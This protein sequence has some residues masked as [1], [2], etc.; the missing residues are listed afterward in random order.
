MNE[1]KRIKPRISDKPYPLAIEMRPLWRICLIVISVIIVSG[2]KKYL[3][4]KKVNILVWMLIRRN[5]WD[6]YGEYLQGRNS[7]IPFVSVDTSTYKAVEFSIAKGFVSL[8]DGRLYVS[9]IAEN[10]YS[11]L[12]NSEIMLEEMDFLEQLGKKLSESKVKGITGGLI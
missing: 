9:D 3:S 12:I 6:E 2:E 1:G 11:V 8:K 7:E 10:L 4:L 5:R